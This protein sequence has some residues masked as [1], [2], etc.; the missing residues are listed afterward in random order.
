MPDVPTIAEQ[1]LDN[2]EVINWTALYAPKRTPQSIVDYLAKLLQGV[3]A[4]PAFKTRLKAFATVPMSPDRASPDALASYL[5]EQTEYWSTVIK[6][7]GVK[8]E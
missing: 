1:G 4:E 3:V 6:R 8:G 5:K 2:F 7:A